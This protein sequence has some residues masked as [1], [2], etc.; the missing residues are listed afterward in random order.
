MSLQA[1][2]KT[3]LALDHFGTLLFEIIFFEVIRLLKSVTLSHFLKASDLLKEPDFD[4]S[5]YFGAAK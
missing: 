1:W 2:C 3:A 4:E 5:A